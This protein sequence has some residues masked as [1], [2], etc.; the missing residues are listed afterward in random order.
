MQDGELP[1]GTLPSHLVPKEPDFSKES[2]EERW[3][4]ELRELRQSAQSS[5][6]ENTSRRNRRAELLR[7]LRGF[8]GTEKVGLASGHRSVGHATEGSMHTSDNHALVDVPALPGSSSQQSEKA[9]EV[10]VDKHGR[11]L[12][13]SMAKS[14]IG[15]CLLVFVHGTAVRCV[16]SSYEPRTGMH[17]LRLLPRSWRQQLASALARF[18]ISQLC[19]DPS[20]L[21]AP[22]RLAPGRTPAGLPRMLGGMRGEP[23]ATAAALLVDTP[24]DLGSVPVDY[25][26]RGSGS[27]IDALVSRLAD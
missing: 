4:R 5:A 14:V 27:T 11:K 1:T 17:K 16:A 21:H 6:N 9:P 20:G 3:R 18:G 10:Y 2:N 12:A 25:W 7:L 23:C 8:D 22:V 19:D 24:S 15:Q 13:Y 26:T